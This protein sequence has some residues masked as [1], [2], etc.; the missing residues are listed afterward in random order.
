MSIHSAYVV[1]RTVSALSVLVPLALLSFKY[2]QLSRSYKILHGYLII[3]ALT[4][5]A[6][7]LF[8]GKFSRFE[9]V[10]CQPC[11]FGLL[12]SF[13]VTQFLFFIWIYLREIHSEVM[14]TFLT[15]CCITFG[16]YLLYSWGLAGRFQES[17]FFL[18]LLE[19]LTLFLVSITAFIFLLRNVQQNRKSD[20]HLLWFNSGVMV[21]FSV[22][23]IL[24]AADDF[25]KQCSK[26]E[27]MVLWSLSLVSNILFYFFVS[28]LAL[29][30][31]RPD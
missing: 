4:E 14:R 9:P 3:S 30:W 2:N 16:A 25:L 24:F 10:S 17:D 26:Q 11:Y 18:G 29:K 8:S 27:F 6:A 12:N 23:V 19:A 5:F 20:K 13:T 1:L 28:L 31:D 22:S 21:Y 15:T 7:H